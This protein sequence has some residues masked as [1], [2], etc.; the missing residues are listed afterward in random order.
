[1]ET[2]PVKNRMYNHLQP[3]LLSCT[4]KRVA[5]LTICDI[6]NKYKTW[7]M[8]H[9][10]CARSYAVLTN[11]SKNG[12]IWDNHKSLLTMISLYRQ[13][14][15]SYF[16]VVDNIPIDYSSVRSNSL[17]ILHSVNEVFIWLNTLR[18]LKPLLKKSSCSFSKPLGHLGSPCKD[19]TSDRNISKYCPASRVNMLLNNSVIFVR[20]VHISVQ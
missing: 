9:C 15:I 6:V 10:V 1:M 17:V 2:R 3:W 8:L 13:L 14:I 4:R 5:L 7:Y 18:S 16:L 12:H 19:T 11:T 20:L